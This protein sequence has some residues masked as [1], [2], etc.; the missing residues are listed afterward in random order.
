M[1]HRRQLINA[2]VLRTDSLLLPERPLPPGNEFGDVYIDDLVF[3]SI[4]HSS[5]SNE[6]EHCSRAARARVL[7]LTA[8]T[9]H[10]KHLANRGARRQRILCCV[11]SQVVL[12]A[13]SKGRSSSR[14]LNFG[15]GGWLSHVSVR[16]CQ[17]IYYG[18]HREE[19]LQTL[20]RAV[21]RLPI[22]NIRF[23]TW[24]QQGPSVHFRVNS[25]CP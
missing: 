5:R 18:S 10:I 3:F 9:L 11:D 13:V 16:L 2:G 7:E 4:L 17:S 1:A 22:G 25:C 19:T 24:P 12:G 15:L 14:R 8:L 21:L 20:R 23:P 6:L